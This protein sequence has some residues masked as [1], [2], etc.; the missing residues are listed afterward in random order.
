MKNL[1]AM[2]KIYETKGFYLVIM[3]EIR[4]LAKFH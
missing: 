2:L 4:D 1:D 3:I